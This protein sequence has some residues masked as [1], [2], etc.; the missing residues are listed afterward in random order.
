MRTSAL[1]TF[2]TPLNSLGRW[3]LHRRSKMRNQPVFSSALRTFEKTRR[4]RKVAKTS[5]LGHLAVGI[6]KRD[7][8]R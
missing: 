1:R 7:L 2:E 3:D 8:R 6:F 5:P 4:F